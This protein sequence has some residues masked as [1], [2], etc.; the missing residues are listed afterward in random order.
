MTAQDPAP[1]VK[2]V[3]WD[4]DDTLWRGTLV[5]GDD[6]VLDEATVEVLRTLDE[7]GILHSIASAN[8]ADAAMAAL[9]RLGVAE[10]FLVP[11]IGWGAKS[12]SVQAVADAL[13][14]GVDSLAFVDDQPFNLQE[15]AHS[16][17][18]VRCLPADMIPQLAGLPEF[19]PPVSSESGSRRAMYRSMHTRDA[20]ERDFDGPPQQFLDGLGMVCTVAAAEPDDLARVEELTIRTHQLNTTG[21]AY[22][23]AELRA[24]ASAPTHRVLVV[25]LE[26][27]YGVYGTIGLALLAVGDDGD[28]TLELFLLSCR[29]LTRGVSSAL[30][31]GLAEVAREQGCVLRARFRP[32]DR[33]R[34]MNVALRFAGFEQVADDD[35]TLL[36]EHRKQIKAPSHIDLRGL[37]QAIGAVAVESGGHS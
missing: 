17:P 28:W 36:L 7:R 19:S 14:I 12:L 30:L 15:V 33:N 26:D 1:F 11:Q 8:D 35:G 2:C 16:L 34:A 29:V 3:V 21:I 5:E 32:N 4:L 23:R 24:L 20:A 9:E 13:N 25:G 37:S 18:A 27:R 22:G 31:A 6:V 10:Y